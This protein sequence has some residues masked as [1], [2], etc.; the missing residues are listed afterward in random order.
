MPGNSRKLRPWHHCRLEEYEGT[1]REALT[2]FDARLD[3]AAAVLRQA[4]CV[5]LGP[6]NPGVQDRKQ[7]QGCSAHRSQRSRCHKA[8]STQ[9]LPEA[10][11]SCTVIFIMLQLFPQPSGHREEIVS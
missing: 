9:W 11:H 5:T 8:C 6:V 3:K 4:G 1:G 2:A 7:R 10:V